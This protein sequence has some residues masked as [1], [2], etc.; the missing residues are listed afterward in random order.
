MKEGAKM[1]TIS[2]R[3][4]EIFIDLRRLGENRGVFRLAA[5]RA[6]VPFD[7]LRASWIATSSGRPILIRPPIRASQ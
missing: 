6:A 3:F 4:D 2:G 5:R 7:K 1:A